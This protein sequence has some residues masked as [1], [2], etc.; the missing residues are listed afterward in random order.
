MVPKNGKN[1]TFPAW[2]A[3]NAGLH[4]RGLEWTKWTKWTRFHRKVMPGQAARKPETRLAFALRPRCPLSPLGPPFAGAEEKQSLFTKQQK[5][6]FRIG[7]SRKCG[8][9]MD[10]MS[11][12]SRRF[13]ELEE[14]PDS[15]E[16][17]VPL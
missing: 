4:V 6:S 10:G 12:G 15:I 8:Y 2:K 11:A 14:S 9:I 16:Q 17:G 3:S 13:S 7:I 1:N 5:K